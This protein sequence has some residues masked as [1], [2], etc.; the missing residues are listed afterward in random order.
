MKLSSVAPPRP[1]RLLYTLVMTLGAGGCLFGGGVP[2]T[3]Y[4]TLHTETP[5]AEASATAAPLR[6]HVNEFRVA[7]EYKTDR[8]VYRE[9]P[10]ELKY[11]GYYRWAAPPEVLV[12]RKVREAL[13]ASKLFAA[14]DSNPATRADLEVDG[15]LER[16][17]EVDAPAGWS[18]RL[19]LE[20]TLRDP[21]DRVPLVERRYDLARPAAARNPLEV[22]KALSRA[23]EDAMKSFIAE[24]DKALARRKAS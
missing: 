5:A 24:T 23:L 12:R 9:S 13:A 21:D 18:G 4:Y 20:L 6:V 2:E 14:V 1:L 7:T 16:I 15:F 17:E 8:L 10:Y 11:Y 19:A 22:V 3:A